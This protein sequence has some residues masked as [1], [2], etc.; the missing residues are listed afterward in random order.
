MKLL[1]FT[2]VHDAYRGLK[3]CLEVSSAN[4]I[5]VS[6][7]LLYRTFYDDNRLFEFIEIQEIF[8]TLTR[9][10][11]IKDGEIRYPYDL[12]REIQANPEDYPPEQRNRASRYIDLF[13]TASKN[14]KEKYEHL[15]GVIENYARGQVWV[16]PGNY[17]MDLKYTAISKLDIHQK[18]FEFEG[19]RFSAYGGAPIMTPGIPEKMTVRFREGDS[20]RNCEPLQQFQAARPDVLLLHQPVYGFFDRIPSVGHVGSTGIRSYFDDH[21][22]LLCLSGHVH[23]DFGILRK[24]GTI[25]MNP[26]N[27][28]HVESLHGVEPGGYYAEID[29]DV[30]GVSRVLLKHWGGPGKIRDLMTIE[31]PPEARAA[32]RRDAE[33]S[34]HLPPLEYCYMDP[35][36]ARDFPHLEGFVREGREVSRPAR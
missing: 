8:H 32:N 21:Q 34:R 10:N 13:E 17:D 4:L 5:I 2:D 19:V 25:F 18:D 29:L 9:K 6:G 3:E 7:D 35:H 20:M 15:K 14:I 30:N 27:F 16:L 33:A 1:Y 36:V 28:G 26:S 12:A 31:N 23:E 11:R 22:P 24:Q